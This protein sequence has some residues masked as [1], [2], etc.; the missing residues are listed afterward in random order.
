MQITR[1]IKTGK[2][3]TYKNPN[4]RYEEEMKP[5]AKGGWVRFSDHK[6]VIDDLLDEIEDCNCLGAIQKVLRQYGR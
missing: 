2:I 6:K 5:H 4:T 1:Y 3:I